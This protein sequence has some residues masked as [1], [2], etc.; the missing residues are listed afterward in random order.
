MSVEMTRPIMVASGTLRRGFSITPADTAAL[1][2]PR[3]AHKAIEALLVIAE[4]AGLASGFQPC[5][6]VSWLNQFQPN[7]PTTAIGMMPAAVVKVVNMPTELA[8]RVLSQM[9][10]QI[11]AAVATLASQ[12]FI[13]PGMNTAR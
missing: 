13:S 9:K 8:P 12:G 4:T 3:K 2:T 6:K 7:N 10:P 1:S 5:M 11:N